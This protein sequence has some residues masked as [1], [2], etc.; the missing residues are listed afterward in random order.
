[1][2]L[3]G[4]STTSM[5]E[6]SEYQAA[7]IPCFTAGTLIA[8]PGGEVPVEL[9]RP[10]DLV[11]T[12]DNGP[13][14]L[15]W[16][17]MR[18]LGPADFAAAPNLRPIEI[19]AGAFGDHG[20]LVV[21]PQHGLLL[22]LADEE[23][24]VRATHLARLR[25]GRARVKAGARHATYCHLLFERHEVVFSNGLPSESYFP[26]PQA[27]LGLAPDARDRIET[28][29]PK[30]LTATT[31]DGTDALYGPPARDYATRNSLPD[32]LRSLATGR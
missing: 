32:H 18:K 21:S 20:A 13:K 1:M 11:L 27:L 31:H 24:L 14:R 12:R 16:S 25:G 30:L 8:T 22:K 23:L 6:G 26:G 9:L 5:D 10:G 28:L 3:Q 15:L 19:R 17:A 7:G 29:F 4:T 2:T